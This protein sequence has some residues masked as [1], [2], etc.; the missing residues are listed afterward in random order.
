[1]IKEEIRLDNTIKT[2]NNALEDDRKAVTALMLN[3]RVDCNDKLAEH[4]TIQVHCYDSETNERTDE[5]SV[6]TLGLLNGLFGISEE[7]GWGAIAA[8][9]DE[10]TKLIK[11]F[12]RIR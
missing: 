12:Q 3:S 10:E 9:I 4:P 5:C 7:D 2:L 1:M 8:V 11:E 6:G